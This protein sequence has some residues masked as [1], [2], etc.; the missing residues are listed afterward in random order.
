VSFNCNG[1]EFGVGLFPFFRGV[2][3]CCISV[4]ACLQSCFLRTPIGTRTSHSSHQQP[5]IAVSCG[6][7]CLGRR[8]PAIGSLD[9]KPRKFRVGLNRFVRHHL[10]PS[11][12]YLPKHKAKFDMQYN[13]DHT[14][15]SSVFLSHLISS[16]HGGPMSIA[17]LFIRGF[18]RPPVL[19]VLGFQVAVRPGSSIDTCQVTVERK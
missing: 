7:Y 3:R 19:H 5:F 13:L 11:L 15:L 6:I 17:R 12:V 14:F 4:A 8:T 2:A 10:H 18:F 1:E 16:T 9:F